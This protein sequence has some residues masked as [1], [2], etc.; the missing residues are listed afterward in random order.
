MFDK[1]QAH[2]HDGWLG[3]PSPPIFR[4]WGIS[5]SSVTVLPPSP[6]M[7]VPLGT[8]SPPQHMA[9]NSHPHRQSNDENQL[10]LNPVSVAVATPLPSTTGL[11]SLSRMSHTYVT[12]RPAVGTLLHEALIHR[13]PAASDSAMSYDQAIRHVPQTV[14]SLGKQGSDNVP[15]VATSITTRLLPDPAR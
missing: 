15:D 5:V 6:R 9:D 7:Y 4:K 11:S 12:Q 10:Q 13:P 3:R 2:D 14:T 8:D 1:G